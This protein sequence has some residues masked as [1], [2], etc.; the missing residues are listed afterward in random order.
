MRILLEIMR[1]V[2]NTDTTLYAAAQSQLDTRLRE[3]AAAHG[4]RLPC[5]MAQMAWFQTFFAAECPALRGKGAQECTQRAMQRMTC[6]LDGQDD[7][8]NAALLLRNAGEGRAVPEI[9]IKTNRTANALF[10]H[11]LQQQYAIAQELNACARAPA[12]GSGEPG[13]VPSQSDLRV[14][15]GSFELQC[16]LLQMDEAAWLVWAHRRHVLRGEV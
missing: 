11:H 9:H 10:F 16:T 4:Q 12:N 2:Q 1:R 6:T 13:G 15:Y 5:Y 14:W 3:E 7:L 8:G